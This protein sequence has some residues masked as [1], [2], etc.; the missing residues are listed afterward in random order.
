[1]PEATLEAM[2]MCAAMTALAIILISSPFFRRPPQA[3]RVSRSA[4][5]TPLENALGL[6]PTW[7][8]KL[9]ERSYGDLS[10]IFAIGD[11]SNS[12]Q[13]AK[14][15]MPASKLIRLDVLATP[16]LLRMLRSW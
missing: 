13:F 5:R 1:M 9:V 8:R 10:R 2:P 6:D 14:P 11:D 4:K 15:S 3:L 7:E 16:I 12:L